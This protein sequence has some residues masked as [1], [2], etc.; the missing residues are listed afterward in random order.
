M[1]RAAFA[2]ALAVAAADAF[3]QPEGSSQ[4]F[5]HLFEW[6]W[7]DIAKECE[8]FLG[9]KG[10]AAVQVSPPTEHIRGS[11]W[12]TRYQPVTYNLTSRGGNEAEFTQMVR[13]C[14]AAGVDIY[15]DAVL[16]HMAGGSGESV[17][18]KQFGA[19]RY[20]IYG[21]EDFHHAPGDISRNCE[22]TDYSDSNN[23]QFCD[24]QGMPDL[25]TECEHVQETIAHFLGHLADLGVAG[26]RLDA[27]KHMRP[28]SL[29]QLF[30]RQ[31]VSQRLFLYEEVGKGLSTDAVQPQA[32]VALGPV[33]EFSYSGQIEEN[34]GVDG[35]MAGLLAFGEQFGLL[36]STNAVVFVDNHDSQRATDA[37]AAKLTHKSGKLY[38]LAVIFMLAHPYGYPQVMSSFRFRSFD[39]GPPAEAVHS[40]SS[41]RCGD[42]HP[43]VCE[44]RWPGIANMVAWR[45]AA[46]SAAISIFQAPFEDFL[47]FCRG[48]S[49]CVLINR[50]PD[51]IWEAFVRLSVP[52]G[53]YCNVAVS[54]SAED[55]PTVRVGT[56]GLTLLSVPPLSAVAVHIG[57]RVTRGKASLRS[58]QN[59]ITSVI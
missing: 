13:R 38:E 46:G 2:F 3:R 21:P 14:R 49:A 31:E 30:G 40:G 37:T 25:C 16:N 7:N 9:P 48:A 29:A 59:D 47:A 20:P 43:W 45:R 5:V 6:S 8:D 58:S 42:G 28:E 24:L 10:F 26:L 35:R 33:T 17:L 22:V 55:C 23:V 18:G 52:S 39:D 15:V 41:L 36:P 54:A 53:L 4:A 32:Y 11:Q 34:L 19:R 57:A 12:W 44:H 56:R 50:H 27:A 51:Q 1:S